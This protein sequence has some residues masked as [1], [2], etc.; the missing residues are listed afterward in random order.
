MSLI[1]EALAAYARRDFL[2]AK[3]KFLPLAQMGSEAAF[4]Y[5]GL[6]YEHGGH[7]VPRD[8]ASA[9]K[10][11]ERAL[12]E[13]KATE[14]ALGLGRIYYF[15]HGVPVDY[16]RAHK[17]YALLE[18]DNNP[19]ALLMLGRIYEKGSGVPQDIDRA[20]ALYK[21]STKTGNILARRTWGALEIRSRSITR[22]LFLSWSGFILQ[23]L[24]S[25]FQPTNK[26]LRSC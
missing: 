10:W 4:L 7:G 2:T 26:R 5:L 25:Y 1:K 17:Y 20:L 13:A 9:I 19:I 14:A 8:C 21:R 16:A 6:I 23:K 18:N 15:G 12:N 11:Y 24:Y 22:G 3:E